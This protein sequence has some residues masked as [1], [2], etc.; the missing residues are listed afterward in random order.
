MP[1]VGIVAN[2]GKPEALRV[3][4]EIIAYLREEGISMILDGELASRLGEP[5]EGRLSDFLRADLIVIV[6]GDGTILRTCLEL[7]DDAPLL[8]AVNVGEKGFLATVEPGEA[9]DALRAFFSGRAEVEERFRLEAE[10][11]GRQ[12]PRALN[13]VCL[14]CR[15]PAKV[16]RA[17]VR[18]G[19]TEIYPVEGDGLIIA[20]PSGS[21]A[22]SLSCGGPV[23][24]PGLRCLLLTPICPMSLSWPVVLPP[25][26]EVEV[27]VIKAREPVAVVD[28]Q[29]VF[30][31][32]VGSVLRARL[33]DKPLRFVSLGPRFYEKLAFRG[34][35]QH[36]QEEGPGA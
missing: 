4:R 1:R 23:V 6:G 17:V 15:I 30:D 34:R 33:S 20:T 12:L 16:L 5:A 28:G 14:T 11:D 18:K 29:L 13:E 22:Y 26:A 10:I 9:I 7:P 24:D 36:G 31:M 19:R 32:E 2:T 3:A 21:T 25:D 35:G 27:K 8:M